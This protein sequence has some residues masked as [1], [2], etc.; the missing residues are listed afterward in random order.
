[1]AGEFRTEMRIQSGRD[2]ARLRHPPRPLANP[3]HTRIAS[4]ERDPA[5]LLE[6]ATHGPQTP[7]ASPDFKSYRT[8][9]FDLSSNH[10]V[11]RTRKEILQERRRL[12]SEY[13]RLFDSVAVL[14]FRHDPIGIAFDNENTDEYEPE[15]GTILPRLRGCES[16]VMCA[17]LYIRSL[18]A[19]STQGTLAQRNGIRR[20]LLRFGSCGIRIEV[21]RQRRRRA[22][23][24]T[25][26]SHSSTLVGHLSMP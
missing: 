25:S 5:A 3:I 10:A 21:A 7:P 18:F 13:G 16:A 6:M 14:L 23:D 17:V 8:L 26:S 1:V 19:G 12:R 22:V 11:A 2:T 15:T 9:G 24:V 4:L 20:L